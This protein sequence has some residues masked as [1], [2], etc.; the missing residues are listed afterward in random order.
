MTKHDHASAGSAR[1]DKP[2]KPAGLSPRRGF[3]WGLYLPL[4]LLALV[5]AGWSAFWFAARSLVGNGIDQA[6]ADARARGD[7]WTCSERSISG[8]P[9]RIEVRCRDV[10][11]ARNSTVGVVTLSSGPIVAI[12][13]PHTPNH[14]IVQ[15]AGPLRFQ[16]ADGRRIEAQWD[17]AE[18]SR[19][20]RSGQLARLSLD[21][22][23]PVVSLTRP[24]GAVSTYVARQFEGHVRRN[25]ARPEVDKAQDLFVRIA[26]MSAGDLDALLGDANP[27]DIDLQATTTQAELLMKGL[28]PATLEAWRLASGKFDLT[29]FSLKK[30]LKLIEATGSF[31]LDDARRLE[32]RIEPSAANIDQF[33][34]IR[35]R[36][37][38]M[39]FASALSG[40]PQP[41][42]PDG[43]RPLPTIDI[44]GGRVGF[45]PI[46]LPIPALQPLY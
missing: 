34:G 21:V 20:M 24:D 41:A 23:K 30:G 15:G 16:L 14:V 22:R 40:R 10:T 4:I 6:M 36:G 31:G 35:L 12:G 29:R 43:A 26:Q 25:P 33:A 39:D 46:R 2:D 8:Y 18:A 45:G 17:L 37:G 1:T 9:F 27:S 11:L 5:V 28:T 44:R 38:A 42:S 19:R 32:G 7:I 3:R 13:Q